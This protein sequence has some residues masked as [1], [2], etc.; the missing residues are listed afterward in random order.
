MGDDCHTYLVTL[1]S[2]DHKYVFSF[3][4]LIMWISSSGT[5]L[6]SV[7]IGYKIKCRIGSDKVN[8]RLCYN[9]SSICATAKL[10]LVKI[11]YK[12]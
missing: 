11:F 5:T 9:G 3:R 2:E 12:I 7:V 6:S 1:E 8:F 4:F 10:S